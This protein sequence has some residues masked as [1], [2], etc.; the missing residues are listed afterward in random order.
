MRRD[1]AE[2]HLEQSFKKAQG[3]WRA[4]AVLGGHITMTQG[5]FLADYECHPEALMARFGDIADR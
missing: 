2:L 1:D 5:I 4:P 3:R